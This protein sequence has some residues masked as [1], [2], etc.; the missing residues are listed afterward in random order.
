MTDKHPEEAVLT[1]LGRRHV[2]SRDMEQELT[3]YLLTMEEIYFGLK[4]QE[5]RMMALQ[6]SIKI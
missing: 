3:E 4:R 6:L 5:A 2:F 1:K